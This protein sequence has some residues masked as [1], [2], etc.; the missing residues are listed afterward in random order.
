MEGCRYNSLGDPGD[1]AFEAKSSVRTLVPHPPL[2]IQGV[3]DFLLRIAHSKGVGAAKQKQSI[4]ERLLVSA[5]GEESRYLMRTLAQHIRV[6]AVRTTMI[7]ALARTL[8]LTR[9]DGLNPPSSEVYAPQELLEATLPLP[10]T[11]KKASATTDTAREEIK[12][13]FA[14]S[15]ILLKRVFVQHPN[16]EHIVRAIL[17]HGFENIADNVPLT[18][19][20]LLEQCYFVFLTFHWSRHTSLSNTGLSNAIVRRNL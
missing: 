14:N 6:G 13:L 15:E 1:V 2:T 9:P 3:Y 20:Q 5:K 12:R 8:V 11:K 10:E 7:S 4:V 19:G 17:D 18:V 16:Y